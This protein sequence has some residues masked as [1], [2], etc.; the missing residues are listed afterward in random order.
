MTDTTHNQTVADKLHAEVQL[1][2]LDAKK[3]RQDIILGPLILT[4]TALGAGAALMTA[5]NA[6]AHH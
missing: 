3:R 5:F 2:I 6:I 4:V 1:L